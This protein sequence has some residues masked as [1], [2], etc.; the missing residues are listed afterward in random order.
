M[1][2]HSR[3]FS[4]CGEPLPCRET[5]ISLDDW[6][7]YLHTAVY[8]GLEL[9]CMQENNARRA[10]YELRRA[11]LLPLQTALETKRPRLVTYALQGFHVS[12]LLLETV[13]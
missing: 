6:K 2:F 11:C 1:A 3:F 13:K 9:L 4:V 5:D 10:S 8:F 7:K 12:Y